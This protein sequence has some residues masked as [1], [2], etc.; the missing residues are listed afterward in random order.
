MYMSLRHHK[1]S[2]CEEISRERL[3]NQSIILYE[4]HEFKIA[5]TSVTNGYATVKM[6]RLIFWMFKE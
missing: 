3:L 6:R 4:Y 5:I 1:D 2:T